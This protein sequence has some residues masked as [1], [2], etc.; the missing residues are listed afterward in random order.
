MMSQFLSTKG[1]KMKLLMIILSVIMLAGCEPSYKEK[2][3]NFTI[4]PDEL[5]DCKFYDVRSN[6]GSNLKIVRCPNSTVSTTYN[7][8]K[9]TLTTVVIDGKKY[10]A[11]E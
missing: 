1:L 5:K 11:T 2:T 6:T 7:N 9:T 4:L 3:Q 8:G 10:E